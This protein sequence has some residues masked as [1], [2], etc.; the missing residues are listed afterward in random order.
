MAVDHV[1]INGSTYYPINKKL[2]VQRMVGRSSGGLPL[3]FTI[4]NATPLALSGGM[5]VSLYISDAV[6]FGG[7]IDSIDIKSENNAGCF[8]DITCAD[9]AMLAQK[10]TINLNADD[11]TGEYIAMYIVDTVLTDEGV[12]Y[13]A[14]SIPDMHCYTF[15]DGNTKQFYSQDDGHPAQE[16]VGEDNITQISFEYRTTA[17]AL[18]ELCNRLNYWW[19]IDAN[20]KLWF[21]PRTLTTAA[22]T[23]TEA[24]VLESGVKFTKSDER[25]RNQQ[26]LINTMGISENVTESFTSDGE[27]QSFTVQYPLYDKP[28][29]YI[30]GNRVSGEDIGIQGLDTGKE[31]YWGKGANIISHDISTSP[32]T[33]GT[34]LTVVYNGIYTQDIVVSNAAEIAARAAIDGTSGIIEATVN[35]SRALTAAAATDYATRLLVTYM[36]PTTALTFTTR[37]SGLEE[38]Q[39]VHVTLPKLGLDTDMFITSARIQHNT[40]TPGGQDYRYTIQAIT[41]PEALAWTNIL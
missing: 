20:K 7:F 28:D 40:V 2:T 13:D 5:P 24:D 39:T 21:A 3:K 35:I 38:G 30:N 1:V 18:D 17:E 27:I 9:M 11:T 25:Y 23:V 34:L 29:L 8:Y 15:P 12:T 22:W 33:D 10:R 36:A 16:L 14:S 4:Y 6:V 32:I 31:W 41:G 19:K 26:R 37:R